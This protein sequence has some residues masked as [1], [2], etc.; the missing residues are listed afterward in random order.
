MEPLQEIFKLDVSNDKMSAS[1]KVK[2]PYNTEELTFG[3][4]KKW[5]NDK[6]IVFGMDTSA[7]NKYNED[8][9]SIEILVE[10][11]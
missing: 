3:N 11:H 1:L 8:L 5:L 10:F 2:Q 4:L 9:D 6:G 7:I